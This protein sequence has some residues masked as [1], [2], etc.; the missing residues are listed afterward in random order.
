MASR[1]VVVVNPT[2]GRGRAARVLPRVR[3]AL[4]DLGVDAD[5]Q[6]SSGPEQP[7][8]LARRAVEDGAE[9]VAAMGGDGMAGMVASA[10][11]GSKAALAVIPTGTGNDFSRMLGIDRRKPLDAIRLLVDP[12]IREIDV[13]RVTG[14]GREAL[15]VNVAGA[16]FDSE[17]TETANRMTWGIQGTA[18]YV[19][20]VVKTLSVWTAAQFDVVVDGRR[21][22]LSGML[23]AVGNGRSYGG[24]MKVCPDASLTDGLLDV[25]VVGGMPRTEFL[26]AFPSVFRGTHVKHPKVRMRRGARVEIAADRPFHVYADGDRSVPLPATFEV[27]PRELRVL[28]RPGGPL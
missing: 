18:K 23:V 5:V 4:L 17:V 28:V 1:V 25:C 9:V 24:G 3:D 11:I 14:G 10:L 15:Y 27:L 13:V 26:R 22:S 6:V 7:P 20:A 8:I 2:S 21:E 12:E 16:G 19:V